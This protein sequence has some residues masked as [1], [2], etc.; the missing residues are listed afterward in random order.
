MLEAAVEEVAV[1]VEV[2]EQ[3]KEVAAK[4]LW[5]RSVHCSHSSLA[6][7]CSQRALR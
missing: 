5:L 6:R 4:T 3:V 7:S 1:K 2:Q